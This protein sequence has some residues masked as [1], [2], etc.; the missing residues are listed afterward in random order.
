MRNGARFCL[1]ARRTHFLAVHYMIAAFGG[2]GNP[3]GGLC[4]IRLSWLSENVHK[5]M[6]GHSG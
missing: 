3:A 2:G 4:H 1:P 6:A 5:A